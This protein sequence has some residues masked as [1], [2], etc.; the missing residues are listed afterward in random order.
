MIQD[1]PVSPLHNHTPDLPD[2]VP[3]PGERMLFP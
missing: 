2:A 1:P 3:V